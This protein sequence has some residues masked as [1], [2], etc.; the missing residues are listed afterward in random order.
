MVLVII[1]RQTSKNTFSAIQMPSRRFSF[2]AACFATPGVG[3]S[4]MAKDKEEMQVQSCLE[5]EDSGEKE[6]IAR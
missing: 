1:S 6:K 4:E 2:P 3:G 5:R